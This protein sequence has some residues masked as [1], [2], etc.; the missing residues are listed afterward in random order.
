MANGAFAPLLPGGQAWRPAAHDLPA[1]GDGRHSVYW[2][3]RLSVAGA[4]NAFAPVSTVRGFL[5]LARQGVVHHDQ[6]LL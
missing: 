6:H 2:I 1:R 5:R 3:E 4:S